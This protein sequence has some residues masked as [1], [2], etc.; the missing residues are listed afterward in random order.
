MNVIECRNLRKEYKDFIFSDNS[1]SIEKGRIVGLIGENGA[2]KTTLIN[3]LLNKI[4]RDSGDIFIF[5]KD[6]AENEVEIKMNT[7][8]VLDECHLP[9]AFNIKEIE[10]FMSKIYTNWN[11]KEFQRL[12]QMFH[13]PLDKKVEGFSRGMKKKL[14]IAAALSHEVS[15]LILDEPTS[16]LDFTSARDI[17]KI[18]QK[19]A[20]KHGKTILFSTHNM[21]ELDELVDDIIM[22]KKGK[23]VLNDTK[24]NIKR[25]YF[26]LEVC[27]QG[28]GDIQRKVKIEDMV[29][30]EGKFRILMEKSENILIDS[31]YKIRQATL[32]EIIYIKMKGEE[33]YE[34]VSNKRPDSD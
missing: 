15:L 19:E 22:L 12:R 31:E 20:E 6:L 28:L 27:E 2:G 14:D 34:G 3:L 11:K 17:L 29:T 13:L 1:F 32:E 16:G 9:A 4:S 23:I 10:A 18:L 33:N 26:L 5:G 25:K 21:N 24:E 7:G 8:V 30:E